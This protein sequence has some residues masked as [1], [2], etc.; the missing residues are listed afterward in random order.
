MVK[1]PAHSQQL[2]LLWEQT[3]D[4]LVRQRWWLPSQGCTWPPQR[5]LLQGPGIVKWWS[6]LLIVWL[7]LWKLLQQFLQESC[8]LGVISISYSIRININ[9]SVWIPGI[10]IRRFRFI[11]C[12][13]GRIRGISIIHTSLLSPRGILFW[14]FDRA[15]A[16]ARASKFNCF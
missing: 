3:V 5:W 1:I 4:T 15:R 8:N 16:R 14:S 11:F 2:W 9:I 13:I 12:I 10:A 6:Y 7:S